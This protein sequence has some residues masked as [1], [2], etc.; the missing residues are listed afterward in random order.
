[1][2]KTKNP[3]DF[4]DLYDGFNSPVTELDCGMLCAPFNKTGKPFCCDIC[5]AVPVAYRFEWDYLE[6]RTTLWHK[7]RGDECLQEPC[8]RMEL[9]KQTPDHLYLLACKGPEH[10]ERDFRATS[11]RQF[12]FFPYITSDFRFI[13]LGYDWDFTETCWV[14]SN[15]HKVTNDYIR[16]FVATYDHLFATWLEDLDSY[17]ALSEEMRDHYASINRRFPILHRNGKTY[18]VS[19]KTESMRRIEPSNLPRFGPYGSGIFGH[20]SY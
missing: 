14:I 18:L 12:P 17:A 16:E 1:M 2:T 6:A 15:L 9:L 13:G 7:W 10:C 4:R 5:R 20:E 8:D 3:I 11:C 19:P